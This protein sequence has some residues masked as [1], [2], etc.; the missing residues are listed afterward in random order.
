MTPFCAVTPLVP[1]VSQALDVEPIRPTLIE[2][3]LIGANALRTPFCDVAAGDVAVRPSAVAA[4]PS[5]PIAL[6]CAVMGTLTLPSAPS[7]SRPTDVVEQL[8]AA[9]A[10]TPAEMAQA[11]TGASTLANGLF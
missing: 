9:P 4:F 6:S 1:V 8:L 7:W 5:R 3:M 10:S 2:Q 11:F